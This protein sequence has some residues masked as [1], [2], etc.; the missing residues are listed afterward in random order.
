MVF[1]GRFGFRVGFAHSPTPSGRASS[2]DAQPADRGRF[3]RLRDDQPRRRRDRSGSIPRTCLGPRFVYAGA[4]QLP[5]AR[6][7]DAASVADLLIRHHEERAGSD[8]LSQ[9]KISIRD[10]ERARADAALGR[11]MPEWIVSAADDDRQS[12]RP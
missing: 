10:M 11:G 1:A 3:G 9:L 12:N 8:L 2:V 6:G 7:P 5:R 4:P